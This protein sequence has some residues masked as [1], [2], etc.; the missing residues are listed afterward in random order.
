M[1]LARAQHPNPQRLTALLL[2]A[3]L[4][5]VASPGRA[6][7]I[8]PYGVTQL[9]SGVAA[10][11]GANLDIT[12]ATNAPAPVGTT[13]ATAPAT[14]GGLDQATQLPAT[15]A[16]ATAAS[17][18]ANVNPAAPQFYDY[19]ANLQSDVFGANLF[20]GAFAR[21]GATPFNPDYGVAIGDSIQIRFWGGF[22]YDAA[23]TVDPQGN[24]FVPHVGPV[25]VLGVRNQDLQRLV[26]SGVRRVFRAN[27]YSYAS[28]AAAQ[29]VRVFVS[30]F[31]NRPGLYNGTSMDSLLHYLDQAGG[32][33]LDRGS[34]LDVQVKR[35]NLV[36]AR[37]NLY[38]FILQ[39]RMPLIQLADGDVIFVSPRQHNVLALGLAANAKR[40][41]FQGDT[42]SVAALMQLAKPQAQATHVR[43]T[44]NT[45]TLKNVEY[46]PLSRAADIGL[47]SGDSVEFT[48]DKKPGT[49][50]VRVEGE[51]LS[52]QEYVVPYGTRLG[53][54]MHPIRYSER[55]DKSSL[56]LFRNSIKDRQKQ[57]LDTALRRLEAAVLTVRSGT[58]EE[59]Q[60]RK[61][62]AELMLQWVAKAK[63]IEPSGQ[64]LLAG[65]DNLEGLLLENG[66]RINIPAIDSLVLVS[67]EVMFP[68]TIAL[69]RDKDIDDYIQSAG[70]YTQ[71]ADTSRIIIAHRDGSFEDTEESGGWFSEQD[72]RPGD[73]ILVLPEVDAKYRQ[74]FK[75]VSTMI[76]QMALGARVVL[77]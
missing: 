33:D 54:L 26:D 14:A 23:A 35:G 17:P 32:I 76:Y 72:V 2:L 62:E 74:L 58:A 47:Q 38:D 46:Y 60:L 27:V 3:A 68:N 12:G 44:R 56:Q 48:A 45:G 69:S 61:A 20:T 70:G 71:G 5:L 8:D 24:I 59:S 16:S 15:P 64:I 4:P 37:F 57:M 7:S 6:A 36:R 18:V 42:L 21:Q 29:P 10:S 19:G 50:T 63:A 66:D 13:P 28:L 49:I 22:D 52:A 39:G 11:Q 9:L 77:K 30:G 51:H 43:I 31:V 25:H 53:Q 41:E 67:G 73:E 34:F 55:A 40:F 1:K 65:G 75:E